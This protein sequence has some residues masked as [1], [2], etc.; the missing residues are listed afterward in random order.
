MISGS[1]LIT[2]NPSF[3]TLQPRL[4]LV[5]TPTLGPPDFVAIMVENPVLSD[6]NIG[7][8]NIDIR[9][10]LSGF[11]QRLELGYDR[12]EDAGRIDSNVRFHDNHRDYW[13]RPQH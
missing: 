13:A 6:F 8:Q 1:A 4:I 11:V 5:P 10:V 2:L 9:T 7:P 3:V 12:N